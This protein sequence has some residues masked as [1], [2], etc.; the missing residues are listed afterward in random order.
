MLT[1]NHFRINRYCA[2][3]TEVRFVYIFA[4]N[5]YKLL[6]SFKF[7]IISSTLVYLFDNSLIVWS[8]YLCTIFPISFVAIVFARIMACCNVNTSLRLQIANSKRTFRSWTKFVKNINLNAISRKYISY[9]L[10]KKTTV[11]ATVVTNNYRNLLFILKIL[12]QIVGEALC[13]HTYC[14]DIH[15]VT[16]C[17]HDTSQTTC[18][19]FQLFIKAFYKISF[20]G[21]I[22]HRLNLRTRF[23]IK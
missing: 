8:K 16:A 4:Y 21:I 2:Y 1:F 7:Y 23:L 13:C 15:T 14:I 17:A 10:C 12:L 22:N 19:K 6:V 5:L 11:V 9:T 18:T 3:H 20:I